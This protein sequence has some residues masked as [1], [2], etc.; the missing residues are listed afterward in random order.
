M[1]V[2]Q[3]QLRSRVKDEIYNARPHLRPFA[4]PIA[5]AMDASETGLDVVDGTNFAKGDVVE[6]EL[7]GEQNYVSSVSSNTLTVIRGYNSTT[8]A[9]H[10]SGD[11]IFKN[12]RVTL[13]QIDQAIADTLL[14]LEGLGVHAWG[15]GAITLITNQFTYDLSLSDCLDVAA[16]YYEDDD[17]LNL[18]PLPFRVARRLHTTVVPG[19]AAIRIPEWGDRAAGED[20]YYTYKKI[21]DAAADLLDRQANMVVKGAVGR[22]LSMFIA[23]STDNPSTEA[24]KSVPPG[25]LRADRRE[26]MSEFLRL[27]FAEQALLKQE[28][29]DLPVTRL[30]ARARRWRP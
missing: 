5:E 10:N 4:H 17:S 14:E 26:H 15:T 19:A 3:A 6:Y 28:E 12:P 27:A 9:T 21:I 25:S 7:D 29:K 20:V 8:A 23:P 11:T 16:V 13:K 30:T 18:R 2:T 24:N 22:L 1:A